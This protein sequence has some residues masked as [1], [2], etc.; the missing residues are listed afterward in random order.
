MAGYCHN[1]EIMKK[2]TKRTLADRNNGII[3][4]SINVKYFDENSKLTLEIKQLGNEQESWRKVFEY[5][6]NQEIETL[7]MNEEVMQTSRIERSDLGQKKKEVITNNS[8]Q[9]IYSWILDESNNVVTINEFDEDGELS[10]RTLKHLNSEGIVI[11]EIEGDDYVTNYE[12]I[13][14]N[15]SNVKIVDGGKMIVDENFFYDE[16]GNEIRSLGIDNEVGEEIEIKK[17]YNLHNK[18]VKE[19]QCMNGKLEYLKQFEYDSNQELIK[20]VSEN[21]FDGEAEVIEI[22]I[23]L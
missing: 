12:Y 9:V 10:L 20:I 8:S 6:G 17:A 18:I 7:F 11:K 22:S 2:T 16:N 3:E 13:M 4:Q 23:E 5:T 15:V 14:G 19:E 1:L 21:L